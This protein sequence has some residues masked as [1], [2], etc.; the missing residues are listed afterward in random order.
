[1]NNNGLQS[2][3]W[4]EQVFGIPCYA[5]SNPCTETLQLAS[6][7]Q[8]HYSV[9]IDPLAD[10][11]QLHHYGF[12]YVDTLIQPYCQRDNFIS[13]P[14][15]EVTLHPNVTL[16]EI[17]SMCDDNFVHGRFHRDFQISNALADQRYKQWLS[18]LHEKGQV[19][20]IQY[21]QRTA[22]FIGHQQ[23]NLLLHAVDKAFQGQGL[24]KH[25][26]ST[27]IEQLF[28]QGITTIESSISATNLAALNLYTSLGFR[29]RKPLDIYHRL[30]Q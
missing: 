8:G 25:L 13:H 28:S 20:G 1:M 27:A 26:W 4:D 29:F 18:Q 16:D 14:H 15:R 2:S 30:T 11:S 6:T 12:Y 5:I 9:K 22:A 17:L 23:G 10:K 3:P 21:R 24:A 7:Q 19:I